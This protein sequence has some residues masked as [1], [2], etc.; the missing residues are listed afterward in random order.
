MFTCNNLNQ[1]VYEI[2]IILIKAI[3]SSGNPPQ[4]FTAEE[5]ILTI[6][7]CNLFVE[8]IP[9]LRVNVLILRHRLKRSES[10]I[11]FLYLLLILFYF[12]STQL[13]I[14]CARV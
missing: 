12:R 11:V 5:Q 10:V 14:K 2:I 3:F 13:Y 1:N 7:S 8:I 6:L 4:V 9:K